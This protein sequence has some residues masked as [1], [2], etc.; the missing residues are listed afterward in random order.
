MTAGFVEACT[1]F[2]QAQYLFSI[3]AA[4][5]IYVRATLRRLEACTEDECKV[6]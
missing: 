6:I 5:N 3:L 1:S 2:N 4:F